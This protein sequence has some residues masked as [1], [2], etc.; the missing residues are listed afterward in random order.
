MNVE[1]VQQV[2]ELEG[3]EVLAARS[4]TQAL[5]LIQSTT[6]DIGL[7]DVRVPGAFDLIDQIKSPD[8]AQQPILVA[9]VAYDAL[10]QSAAL[11]D[12]GFD[13]CLPKPVNTRA[14]PTFLRNHV[15]RRHYGA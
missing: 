3:F 5:D 12:A 10:A 4:A 13:D 9:L 2:L 15:A 7:I 1:I 6:P 14:L 11:L 8:A